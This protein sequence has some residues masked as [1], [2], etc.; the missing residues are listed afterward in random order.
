M[1][2]LVFGKTADHQVVHLYVLKNKRGLEVEITN[3]GG[4]V[5]SV[6][7]PDKN[8]VVQDVVLGYDNLEDYVADNALFG[9]IVGRYA[10]RIAHGHFTLDGAAYELARNDGEHHVHG[11]HRG[12]HKRVWIVEPASHHRGESLTMTYYSEDGEEGY[13]GNLTATVTYELTDDNELKIE[14]SAV[15]DKP[16]V[17]NLTNHC[18]F[19]LAGHGS[20]DILDHRVTIHS[21]QFAQIDATFIPT[22]EIRNTAETPFDFARAASIGSRIHNEDMQLKF[23]RGYDH[24]WVLN[25]ADGRTPSLAAEVHEPGS[26]RVLEVWTSEPGVQFYTGNFLDGS[27]HGKNGKVYQHRY[28]FSLETQHFPDSPN[29]S[30]FPSTVLRPG[31]RFHSVTA[32]RFSVL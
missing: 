13:P 5:V 27:I 2:E 19:N 10:G 14:Y 4:V 15:T 28:G 9:A 21:S 17:L 3:Y 7:C 6:K 20:G 16:T 23:G 29:R 31:Q 12:F 22:G 25:R 26:G 1:E 30:A 24:C 8:G 32:Y 18:Y 11:G